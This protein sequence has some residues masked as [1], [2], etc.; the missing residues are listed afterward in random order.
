M[1]IDKDE[2]ERNIYLRVSN[3]IESNRI[4]GANVYV[5]QNGKVLTNSAYGYKT[6]DKRTNLSSE[7]IFRLAS[8]TKPIVAFAVLKLIEKGYIDLF[9]TAD[10]YI[11]GFS[12]F[13]IGEMT[14]EGTV[15]VKGK[16]KNDIRILHLLTHTSGLG[17]GEIWEKQY[18]RMTAGDKYDLESAVEFYKTT[19]LAFEPYCGNA[20]S[21]T[22]AFDVLARI[23]EIVSDVSIEEFLKEELFIPLE[24]TDT[25]FTP[26]RSQ[27]E[28]LVDMHDFKNGESIAVD[29]KGSIFSDYPSTYRCGG[30]GLVSTVNDYAKFAAM[31]LNGG[32]YNGKRVLSEHLV[33]SMRLPHILEQYDGSNETWGLGVR[34]IKDGNRLPKGSFGWSGAYGTHFWID[35][36]NGIVAIYLKNSCYDGGSGAVTAANFEKDVMNSMTD[37]VLK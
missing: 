21:A 11:N 24:M 27:R 31:L 36:E 17:S 37:G 15:S 8:M 12:G 26:N 35:P 5:S 7:N 2:L 18:S 4:L 16:A 22:A 23:V 9:D 6:I 13:Y 14:A 25:T 33:R 1:I 28:R 20:Y 19:L 30:A 34:V 3:D 32:M 29:M 10:I